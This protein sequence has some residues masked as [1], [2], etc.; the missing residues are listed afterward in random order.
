MVAEWHF[1]FLVCWNGASQPN[2][3]RLQLFICINVWDL[4]L[5]FFSFVCLIFCFQSIL[6]SIYRSV[7]QMFRNFRL[8]A[9]MC[10]TCQSAVS[11]M[12]QSIADDFQ[13]VSQNFSEQ[14]F[15]KQLLDTLIGPT[16]LL[17]CLC[18]ILINVTTPSPQTTSRKLSM[19][20]LIRLLFKRFMMFCFEF[21]RKQDLVES[22]RH[23]KGIR[24]QDL[25][26]L[27]VDTPYQVLGIIMSNS[28][29]LVTQLP[30]LMISIQ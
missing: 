13:R 18:N 12:F 19:G 11:Q 2:K 8:S 16:S 29:V 6:R 5:F 17:I 4:F 25:V 15:M 20:C 9:T 14:L 1:L 28:L 23:K 21:L 3:S 7:I 27:P 22:I 30:K 10:N 26:A 24:K